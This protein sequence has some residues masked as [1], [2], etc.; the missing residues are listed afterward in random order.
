M[1]KWRKKKITEP[2]TSVQRRLLSFSICDYPG[3]INDLRGCLNDARQAKS[4]LLGFWPD[5]DT[6]LFL[7]AEARVK[8]FKNNVSEAIASLSPGAT[9]LIMADSCFS[10]TITRRFYERGVEE[11][12][13]PRNRFYATPG[14]PTNIISQPLFRGDL[15]WISLSGCGETDVSADAFINDAYHGAFSWFAFRLLGPGMTYREW[16][17]E[18][19]KYLPNAEFEQVPSLEG[20]DY[21]LDRVVC[22]DQTLIIHN[23]THG[24]TI[25]GDQAIVFYDG[26]LR[27]KE[28]FGLLSKI[29]A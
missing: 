9:V 5:F 10:G 24:T 4:T 19:R 16:H 6:R 7:D 21:L 17:T 15:R 22:D 13:I 26:N 8:T 28:Y 2:M 18:I 14:E 25:G 1:C 29:P 11:I 20:A 27:D 3:S 12:H 23:S